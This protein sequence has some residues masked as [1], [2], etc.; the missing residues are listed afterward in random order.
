MFR[1]AESVRKGLLLLLIFHPR[2]I[3]V[4][5]GRK[6]TRLAAKARELKKEGI[7]SRRL[8]FLE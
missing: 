8:H 2:I 5:L 4:R 6:H 3:Y 7:Y 1:R